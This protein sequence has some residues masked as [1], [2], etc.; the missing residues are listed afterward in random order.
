VF[1]RDVMGC[2]GQA[3]RVRARARAGISLVETAALI[4]LVGI[5]LATFT[6]TFVRNLRMS[7]IAEAVGELDGLYRGAAAYYAAEHNVSGQLLRRCLPDSA[8]PL[9]EQPT[10]EA[11][12]VDFDDPKLPAGATFRALG[13]TG[14]RELR[15]SYSVQ[16]AQPGCG[17]R[18]DLATPA[19]VFQAKGDLDGDGVQSSL[20]R[21]AVISQDQS[22]L[23]AKSPL[24][25]QQRVE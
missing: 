25:I 19:V 6:P 3:A 16:I 5:L 20:K 8:G 12:S 9:P 17:A 13:Q 24:H 7:K 22:T 2:A 21:E 15:Y 11:Q 14:V 18:A 1:D 4:S 10:P 23:D